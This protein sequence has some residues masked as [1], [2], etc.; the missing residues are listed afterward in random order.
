MRSVNIILDNDRVLPSETVSGVIV[1]QTDE[2]F[3]CNRVVLKVLSKERTEHGSGDNQYIDEENIMSRVF[4]VSE[5][6]VIPVGKTTFE[7]SFLLP[8]GL[9]PTYY[10]YN[11]HIKHTLE[12]VVEVNWALDPKMTVEYRVLQK[13]PPYISETIDAAVPSQSEGGLHVR[14]DS[15]ILRMDK[16]I[17]VRF[18]FEDRKRMRRVRC[19]VIKREDYKCGRSNLHSDT[20]LRTT[21]YEIG[22]DDWGRWMDLRVGERWRHHLPFESLLYKISFYLKV[23]LEVGLRLDPSVKFLLRFSDFTP[24]ENEFDEETSDSVFADW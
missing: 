17:L 12:A 14:L 6:R 22:P 2:E 9:P 11:G 20:S 15:N 10:G 3:E 8:R 21:H 19:E 4:R 7:F 1:V 23:T 18:E 13:K 24:E 5:G 16:G